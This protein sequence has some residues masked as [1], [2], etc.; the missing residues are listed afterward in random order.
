MTS[1][2]MSSLLTDLP[3]L[4]VRVSQAARTENVIRAILTRTRAYD[5]WLVT[6]DPVIRPRL[7]TWV[8]V[9]EAMLENPVIFGV[10]E[11]HGAVRLSD[12][13]GLGAS[14]IGDL[15]RAQQEGLNQGQWNRLL[16]YPQPGRGNGQ[17]AFDWIRWAVESRIFDWVAAAVVSEGV[18]WLTSNRPLW[19]RR[20]GLSA[21][22]AYWV[23]Y[24]I[25]TPAQ[26]RFL[27][28]RR[29]EWSSRDLAM[30]LG[31]EAEDAGSLLYALGYE[32]DADAS[33]WKWDKSIPGEERRQLWI[34]A[35]SEYYHLFEGEDD[36]D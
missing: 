23:S 29:L 4:E 34:T 15:R 20:K 18:H 2:G 5:T 19:S 16:L 36:E 35:E 27:V 21:H 12:N 13:G 26:M 25:A 8:T 30:K 9:S 33:L 6:N 31:I 11:P 3:E 24:G 22:T 7:G 32:F 14:S 1:D 28:E 10:T 17:Y